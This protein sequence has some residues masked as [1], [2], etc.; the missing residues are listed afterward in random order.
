MLF[1]SVPILGMSQLQIWSKI[2][3]FAGVRNLLPRIQVTHERTR[4]NL[5]ETLA[6]GGEKKILIVCH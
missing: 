1:C 5:G 6:A 4:D 2:V 3:N